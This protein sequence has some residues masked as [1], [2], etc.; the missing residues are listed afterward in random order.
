[1]R[2]FSTVLIGA[3]SVASLFAIT[4]CKFFILGVG[5]RHHKFQS[6]VSCTDEPGGR[7]M[8]TVGD[9][10]SYYAYRAQS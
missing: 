2:K 6:G 7:S 10:C 3:A 8:R 4:A 5:T 1:M 9:R